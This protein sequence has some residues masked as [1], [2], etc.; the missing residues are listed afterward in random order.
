MTVTTCYATALKFRIG[1]IAPVCFGKIFPI[2]Q[3]GK[4][5]TIRIGKILPIGNFCPFQTALIFRKITSLSKKGENHSFFY[6]LSICAYIENLEKKIRFL[7]F[8]PIYHFCPYGLTL[9][10]LAYFGPAEAE[11]PT[12][13]KQHEQ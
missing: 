4:I 9:K 12:G 8:L 6:N 1:K 13:R 7:P 10:Y 3:I 2:Y 5:T 11:P